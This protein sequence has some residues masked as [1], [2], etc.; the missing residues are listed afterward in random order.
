MSTF[1][2]ILTGLAVA[3][4]LSATAAQ[5]N[6][7][8]TID[9]TNPTAV[10]ITVTGEVPIANDSGSVVTGVSLENFFSAAVTNCCSTDNNPSTLV[11]QGSATV[12]DDTFVSSFANGDDLNIYSFGGG[13]LTMNTTLPAF[14]GSMVVDLSGYIGFLP[15]VGQFGQVYLD[16]N[17]QNAGQ[18]APYIGAWQSV[19]TPVPLPAGG[20]LLVSAFGMLALRARRKAV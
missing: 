6:V 2:M 18:Q 17:P 5:A 19:A 11:G 20:L 7:L 14:T 10:V 3:A 9:T 16:D 12:L 13:T 4:G 8:F 15:S 1:R